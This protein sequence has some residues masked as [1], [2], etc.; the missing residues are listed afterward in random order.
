MMAP[1]WFEAVG[2]SRAFLRPGIATGID[3]FRRHF[4][5][6]RNATR[7]HA[8]RRF[9]PQTAKD[10]PSCPDKSLSI[11]AALPSLNS[12]PGSIKVVDTFR[13]SSGCKARPAP[14]QP[15]ATGA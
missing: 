11:D 8:R 9:D 4:F 13:F 14:L 10:Q 12:E 3:S 1:G 6:L 15:E 7:T 2:S 5:P